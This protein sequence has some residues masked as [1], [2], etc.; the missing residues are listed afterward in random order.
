VTKQSPLHLAT[1][2][3]SCAA[4]RLLLEKG[5]KLVFSAA[6]AKTTNVRTCARASSCSRIIANS[7]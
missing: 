3:G 2:A 1:L 5:A 4:V 6:E 7:Q